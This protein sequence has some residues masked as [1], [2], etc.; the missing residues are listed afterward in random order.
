MNDH[1]GHTWADIV[2]ASNLVDKRIALAG[3]WRNQGCEGCVVRRHGCFRCG[4]AHWFVLPPVVQIDG[5]EVRL[6]VC[7]FERSSSDYKG[8]PGYGFLRRRRLRWWKVMKVRK[9]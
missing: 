9:S 8:I 7:R 5:D 1:Q 4:Y 2:G 6:T 3:G